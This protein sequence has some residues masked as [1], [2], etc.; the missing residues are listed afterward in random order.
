MGCQL[1]CHMPKEEAPGSHGVVAGVMAADGH[2]D[3]GQF[4]S[5]GCLSCTQNFI[6]VI[7]PT[8][9]LYFQ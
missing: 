9:L 3:D 1:P 2:L 6:S 7:S 5:E 8:N 4:V